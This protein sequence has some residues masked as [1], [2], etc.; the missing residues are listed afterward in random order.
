MKKL[1][2]LLCVWATLPA[3]AQTS[4]DKTL[5][6]DASYLKQGSSYGQLGVHFTYYDS[7]KLALFAGLAGNFRSENGLVAIPEA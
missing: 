1:F 5:I 2:L 6:I 7:N 3:V 4:K